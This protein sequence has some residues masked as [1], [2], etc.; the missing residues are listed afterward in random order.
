M[1][2]Y[3]FTNLGGQYLSESGQGNF[4]IISAFHRRRALNASY[5]I[6]NNVK[7]NIRQSLFRS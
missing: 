4:M 7:P 6:P 2:C 5:P 1:K 3:R